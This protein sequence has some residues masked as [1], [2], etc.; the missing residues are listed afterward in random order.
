LNNPA[1]LTCARC[2]IK[3]L[4][5]ASELVEGVRPPLG[6]LTLDDGSSFP[7]SDD[8]VLGREPSGDELVI[9]GRAVPVRIADEGRTVSRSHALIRLVGWDALLEDRGSA[10]GTFHRSASHQ[11]WRRL[12]P[13]DRVT[14]TAG[15]SVRLGERELAFEQYSVL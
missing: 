13:D 10:N 15:A 12:G 2:G 6:V 3:L 1:A 11:P 4:A 8:V 5:D 9:E 14:L 7:L